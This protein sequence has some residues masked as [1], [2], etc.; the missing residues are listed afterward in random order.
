[1]TSSDPNDN[2]KAF[3]DAF[4]NIRRTD[5]SASRTDKFESEDDYN[6]LSVELLVEVGSFICVAACML[7]HG[8]R[9]SRNEAILGGHVVRLYKL[10]SALL[11]QICQRRREIAF[12][13]GRLAFECVVN[14]RF[15]LKNVDDPSVFTSY[16]TYSL[17][18]ERR[19]SGQ[20]RRTHSEQG[21]SGS[22]CGDPN[23]QFDCACSESLRC[24]H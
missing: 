16:V 23:A 17:K 6:G 18:T 12:I 21:G 20:N 9:W 3:L 5:V 22:S 15:L 24:A 4:G 2:A 10:I 1:M 13:I 8:R 11:D 7:P 19:T 14:L